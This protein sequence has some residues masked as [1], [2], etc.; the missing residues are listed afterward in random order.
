MR[1]SS[2]AVA[3]WATTA[4]ETVPTSAA[5]PVWGG[6]ESEAGRWDGE[7]HV[8]EVGGE[9][10]TNRFIGFREL[11]RRRLSRDSLCSSW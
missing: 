8:P 6:A 3:D 11:E 1:Q 7:V 10:F 2:A 9:E 4:R 5:R